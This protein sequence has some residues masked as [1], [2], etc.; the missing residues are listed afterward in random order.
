MFNINFKN[1]KNR[2]FVHRADRGQTKFRHNLA[3]NKLLV[4]DQFIEMNTQVLTSYRVY[5]KSA[6]ERPIYVVCFF[7]KAI[8]FFVRSFAST[9]MS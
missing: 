9:Q 6:S 7:Y 3:T 4:A 8:A 1:K 5:R 2:T